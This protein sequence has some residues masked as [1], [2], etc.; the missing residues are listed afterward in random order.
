AH[1][2]S[3]AAAYNAI[4]MRLGWEE[5]WQTLRRI[6]ANARYFTASATKV[7]VDVGSGEAAAGMCIDFYGRF[8]AGAVSAAGGGSRV[9]YVDPPFMTAINADPISIMRG[10]ANR[11]LA[12]EFVVWLL[13]VQ[14][15]RLWQR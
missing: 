1:S 10:T 9:G 4:V 15:Q 13:S 6:Y 3:I 7:P 8:Q 2:G 14:G 5:G 12:N 11:E